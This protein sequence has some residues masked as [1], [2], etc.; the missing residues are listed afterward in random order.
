MLIAVLA[1]V[2]VVLTFLALRPRTA[3]P[4]PEFV[5]AGATSTP[6]ATPSVSPSVSPSVTPS[7]PDPSSSPSRDDSQLV[8]P[9]EP[10][11]V[12][13]SATVAYRA[14]PGTCLGGGTVFRTTDAGASW[15]LLE[16]PAQAVLTLRAASPKSLQAVVGSGDTCDPAVLASSDAGRTWSAQVDESLWY[17]L[18]GDTDHIHAPSGP[19]L[20]PCADRTLPVVEVQG[21]TVTDA[22]LLCPDGAVMRSIDGGQF[23]QV[24][25]VSGASALAFEG[26]ELGWLL[27]HDVNGCPAYV[28]Y[29]TV[30]GGTTWE[31]GGCVGTSDEL[32][33]AQPPAMAFADTQLGMVTIGGVT[34]TT[35]D[36]GF[37]WSGV[38]PPP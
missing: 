11:L 26:R 9:F 25:S 23:S 16:V 35:N 37:T 36:G 22:A 27:V 3:P 20:N 8:K 10:P 33:A 14:V 34:Y 15:R 2:A 13:V 5:A 17:R 12:M 28:L 31:T 18:G 21:L 29:R 7:D 24:S 4:S 1:V 6:S 32:A 30:D 19:V 38:T